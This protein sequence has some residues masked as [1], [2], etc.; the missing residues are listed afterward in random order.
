MR[1]KIES[2]WPGTIRP[3]ILSPLTILKGQAEALA[4]QTDGLLLVEL[5]RE[6]ISDKRSRLLVEFV[7]PSLEGYRH[8]IM[9]VGFNKDLPFP[10]VVFAEIFVDS[11]KYMSYQSFVNYGPNH[12]IT[13]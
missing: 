8:R 9:T 10:C 1:T 5:T 4:L 2:L 6:D 7:V 12:E 11:I 13:Y 3:K